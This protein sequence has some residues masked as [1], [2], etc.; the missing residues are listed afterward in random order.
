M[1]GERDQAPPAVFVDFVG[2]EATMPTKTEPLY[3]LGV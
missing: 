3:P 1:V 2:S